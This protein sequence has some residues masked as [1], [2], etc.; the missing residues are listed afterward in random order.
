MLTAGAQ[1]D[2][3]KMF[4]FARYD[5]PD[6]I[7]VGWKIKVCEYGSDKAPKQKHEKDILSSDYSTSVGT[8]AMRAFLY[9]PDR[10]PETKTYMRPVVEQ[11]FLIQFN[12]LPSYNTL[13]GQETPNSIFRNKK[14]KVE[15]ERIW[16]W[17]CYSV[18]FE[19]RWFK[20]SNG[21][22]S[23]D[24]YIA[25][26]K[27]EGWG[28]QVDKYDTKTIIMKYRGWSPHEGIKS[29]DAKIEWIILF[30]DKILKDHSRIE[31]VYEKSSGGNYPFALEV[32][33]Q[34]N[35]YLDNSL[36]ETIGDEKYGG[37]IGHHRELSPQMMQRYEQKFAEIVKTLNEEVKG[38]RYTILPGEIKFYVKGLEE[39]LKNEKEEPADSISGEKIV[40]EEDNEASTES[41]GE[42]FV[43]PTIIGGVLMGG[44]EWLRR[45]R[46]KKKNQK[47]KEEEDEEE[48]EEP[49]ELQM[50]VYKDFGDT[51]IAG[52]AAQR[53][54]AC[55]LRKRKG[56]AEWVDENLTRQISISADDDYLAV[57]E[58][59]MVN[60]WKSAF[61]QAPEHEEPPQEGV[62]KFVLESREA[63][64]TNRLHF[65]I[66]RSG[67]VFAQDNLTLPAMYNKE[68]RL[69][70]LVQGIGPDEGEVTVTI[71]A[72]ER[73]EA[74]DYTVE[75]VWDDKE[76]LW[77]AVIWD[78]W[79]DELENA[80]YQSGEFLT[81]YVDVE[82]R[83]TT[84]LTLKG[85]LPLYRFYMGLAFQMEG[86]DVGCYLE[87]YD[88]VHHTDG[89]DVVK[90]DGKNYA[91]AE[92]PCS[93]RL[94]DWD[95][96]NH[97]LVVI[98]PVVSANPDDFKVKAANENE[99]EMVDKLGLQLIVK[100]SSTGAPVY[101]LRCRR[102]V[103]NAP[104]R[105]NA[106][107]EVKSHMGDAVLTFRHE[108]RL[109]SQPKPSF[110]SP[111]EMAD[112]QNEQNRVRDVLEGIDR[113]ITSMGLSDRLAPLVQYIQLQ[114]EAFVQ[115]N[116]FGFDRRNVQAIQKTFHSVLEGEQADA[117]QHTLVACDNLQE[118]TWEYF[119]AMR[120]TVNDMGFFAKLFASVATF[121]TF[122]VAVSV[123]EVVGEMKDYVDRGGDSAW[124]AFFVGVKYVTKKYITEKAMD[125]GKNVV[126][127]YVKSGGDIK[128]TWSAT[129]TDVKGM[130]TKE[131][132]SVRNFR[133]KSGAADAA[134]AANAQAKEKADGLLKEA[135]GQP[136]EL[137]DSAV[138]CGKVRAEKNINEVRKAIEEANLHPTEANII[139]KNAMIM[140]CQGDK[141]TMF[142][143]RQG[144]D[145]LDAV[146]K[147]LNTH[148]STIYKATD[149]RVR[150]ILANKTGM[151]VNEIKIMN[152]T[153]S[154]SA[155]L[156]SGKS[157]TFDRD[158]TYFY[159]D[160]A[161]GQ[162]KYF[163]Q[164]TVEKIYA[165]QFHEVAAA[166]SSM[167]GMVWDQTQAA[168]KAYA[169]KM[170]QTVVEDV[171]GHAESYGLDL[172]KM[173]T[174]GLQGEKLTDPTKVAQAVMYKGR[175]RF[176][177]AT[178][179]LKEAAAKTNPGEKL[180]LQSTAIGEIME[181]C[182]QQMKV[183]DLLDARDIA[184]IGT[185]GMSKIPSPLREGIAVIRRMVEGKA[186]MNQTQAALS[187]LGFTLNSL[188]EAM[189]H[190]VEEIG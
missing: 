21:K 109:L 175:E 161:T 169:K 83:S 149:N 134:K 176:Y 28:F 27:K 131:I 163:S 159:V 80:R 129:K 73:G 180:E 167:S 185:N 179:M 177:E 112:W 46:K 147:E 123:I 14:D 188:T 60:G 110:R 20:V 63:S 5:N 158:I 117:N 36:W 1:D 89:L 189:Y 92:T 52:D 186:D 26:E 62:V 184:R 44:A 40:H 140:R 64:Y 113:Q 156:M 57:E 115:D 137:P 106:V 162:V 19:P 160:K 165:K 172:G 111:K 49:D 143:L 178:K 24:D 76:Q 59:G 130:V 39:I 53:I 71:R 132:N 77:N 90:M 65:R 42:K 107:I 181:G 70:F 103:L 67:V 119:R 30:Y 69:P 85:R 94:F 82:A 2:K 116:H 72:K 145:S 17:L 78:I 48:D 104:N 79:Q 66:Q 55:I 58:D 155:K 9:N 68:V 126:K 35:S 135:K 124:G 10:Y 51:L 154:N 100:S 174:E 114:L 22:V 23:L 98:N 8:Y 18:V 50:E 142:M 31:R 144:G 91:P 88:P 93:L 121:G 54:S 183:F 47:K 43:I 4:P 146:R 97:S 96:N 157:V 105:I 182:R 81:Y 148:L 118:V 99:Q 56:Y 33:L 86:N 122:D 102:G 25:R 125:L 152:A 15:G 95:E 139:R 13:L 141:Q 16:T 150:H 32:E 7:A 136:K 87:E 29:W 12:G 120:T 11:E 41:G 45:R 171:L 84:G 74:T 173:I 34:G 101:R 138:K 187:S 170:D 38:L 37:G 153:S 6:S 166:G 61:V 164:G 128:N 127:N 151:P 168:A 190:T 3:P 75:T 108:V 133:K